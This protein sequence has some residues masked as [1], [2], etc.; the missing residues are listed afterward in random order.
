MRKALWLALVMA[1][2]V[3]A[4]EK[5][6]PDFDL[7]R[8]KTRENLARAQRTQHLYAFKERRT[9]I[10][11]NIFGRV[12]TDGTRVQEVY[13]SLTRGLTYRRVIER[14]GVPVSAAE[15]A[16][17]DRDYRERAEEILRRGGSRSEE[18]RRRDT[19]IEDVVDALQFKLQGRAVRDGVQVVV[20]TFAPRPGARPS[21]RQGRIA[22][23]FT[24]T[25][26]IH[27][28]LFEV[29][30]VEA[31]AIDDLSYGFGIIARLDEGTTAL[32]V[33]EPIEGGLWMPTQLRLKGRGRAALVRRLVIDYAVDWFDYRRLPGDSPAPFLDPRVQ[34]EAGSRPE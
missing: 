16:Q 14:D 8:Q 22:Q 24:G 26:W 23:K 1:A 25:V 15:L 30:R 34:G 29:M 18:Q 5:P 13:P 28:E 33:R 7:L 32:L 12:G 11:A 4:Q 17:Q 9:E 3:S 27:E 10:H 6:L 2:G 21:T 31:R 19:M 20:V